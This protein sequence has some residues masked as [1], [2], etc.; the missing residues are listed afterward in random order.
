M[1]EF[2]TFRGLLAFIFFLT[3]LVLLLASWWTT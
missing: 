2:K 1:D 3:G